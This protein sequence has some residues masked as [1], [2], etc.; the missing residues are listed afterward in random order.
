[1]ILRYCVFATNRQRGEDNCDANSRCKMSVLRLA[2]YGG[3]LA[4][5]RSTHYPQTP[6]GWY[7]RWQTLSPFWYRQFRWKVLK[8]NPGNHPGT[9]RDWIWIMPVSAEPRPVSGS[10]AL[11]GYHHK[12]TVLGV[13]AA[14]REGQ[15]PVSI[16]RCHAQIIQGR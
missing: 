13:I 8:T 6:L 11:P 14:S 15:Q 2:G 16:F 9:I 7:C 5:R 12:S 4:A 1:M 10:R 3:R